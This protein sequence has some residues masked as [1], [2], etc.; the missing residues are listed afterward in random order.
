VAIASALATDAP[1][2]VVTHDMDFVGEACPTVVVLTHGTVRHAGPAEAA[3]ERLPM[4][5]EAGLEPHHVTRL[6]RELGLPATTVRAGAFLER[7]R[8]LT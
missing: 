4:I 8:G 1:V 6:A 7:F 2:L 3:F 5:R